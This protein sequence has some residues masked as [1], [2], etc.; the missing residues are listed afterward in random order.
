ME[1]VRMDFNKDNDVFI[2]SFSSIL[3]AFCK[4]KNHSK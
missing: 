1:A 2:H 4:I 3:A